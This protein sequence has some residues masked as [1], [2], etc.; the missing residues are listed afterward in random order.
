MRNSILLCLVVAV[1]GAAAGPMYR[2]GD[3]GPREMANYTLIKATENY[4]VRDYGS[5]TWAC[6]EKMMPP[7]EEMMKNMK[8]DK[9]KM[10][11]EKMKPFMELFEYMKG[12]NSMDMDMGMTAP[13]RKGMQETEEGMKVEVCVYVPAA[14]Q[15]SPPLPV[16]PDVYVDVRPEYTIAARRVT[17][18]GNMDKWMEAKELMKTDLEE[19]GEEFV[20]KLMY[21]SHLLP[22][23]TIPCHTTNTDYLTSAPGIL[24]KA[25]KRIHGLSFGWSWPKNCLHTFCL[26]IL[27]TNSRPL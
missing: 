9:K 22:H 8:K 18:M 15:A 23:V 5:I 21:Y 2:G 26:V 12:K 17:E 10:M 27:V 14:Q 24:P 7:M 19:A 6:C 25:W 13:V 11:K 1:V 3:D 20:D 4:E 16:H